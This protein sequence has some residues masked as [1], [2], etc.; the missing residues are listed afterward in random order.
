MGL[1]ASLFSPYAADPERAYGGKPPP[2]QI[3]LNLG[4]GL[5]MF[6]LAFVL[7]A[8][9]SRA[10]LPYWWLAPVFLVLSMGLYFFTL[11]EGGRVLRERRERML[12]SI[13][14]SE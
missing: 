10:A 12:V 9:G 2:A 14:R 7:L 11:R 5:S 8:V 3:V 1:W 4:G 6:G 13:E